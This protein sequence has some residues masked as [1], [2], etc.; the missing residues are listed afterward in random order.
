SGGRDG[1]VSIVTSVSP[2]GGDVTEPVSAH[3]QRFVQAVWSLDRDL[4]YARHYPAISWRNSFSRDVDAIAHWHAT[5]DD[6]DWASRR[7][8]LHALLA[9]VDRLEGIADLVG[10]AALPAGERL[11]LL[12]SRLIRQAVLQQSALSD[13]DASCG[14]D[15]QAALADAVLAVHDAAIRL[16]RSGVPAS[17]IEEFDYGPLIRAKDATGSD[18]DAAVARISAELL[19]EMEAMSP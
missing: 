3:T 10:L 7:S 9:E 6:P 14:A 11:T 5:H 4:A 19:E 17:L 18:D 16:S 15:K 8:R 12:T 1:A 13:N 2:P